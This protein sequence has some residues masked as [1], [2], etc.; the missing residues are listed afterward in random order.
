MK[1]LLSIL[2]ATVITCTSLGGAI[3]SSAQE[4]PLDAPTIDSEISVAGTNSF[5]SLLSSELDSE[6]TEQE[7]NNGCNVFSAEVTDNEVTVDFETISDCT[8]LA[9]IYDESEEALIATGTAPVTKEETEKT[10]AIDID[11]MPQY[12]YL[13]VYLVDETTMRPMCSVYESP[14]YTQEM[15]E[16]FAMTVDDF[17]SDR[18]LNFD[19]D[20]TNNFAVYGDSAIIV[21]SDETQNTIVSADIDNE[22]YVIGNADSTVT[23]LLAGDIFAVEQPSGDNLIIKVGEISVDGTTV[24]ITGEEAEME[25]VFDYVKIDTT[26]GT[27]NAEFDNSNLTDGVTYEGRT[28]QTMPLPS[29]MKTESGSESAEA[30]L[31]FSFK[32]AEGK[33]DDETAKASLSGSVGL[34]TEATL[35]YYISLKRQYVEV[36]VNNTFNFSVAFSFSMQKEFKLGT[37]D[38]Y[39]CPGVYVSVVPKVVFE[40]ELTASVSFTVTKTDGFSVEHTKKGFKKENLG[41]KP[42]MSISLKVE[43]TLSVGVAVEANICII[44]KKIFKAGFEAFAKLE[45]SISE[46]TPVSYLGTFPDSKHTCN[47]CLAGEISVKTGLSFS[48]TFLN[49]K[50]LSLKWSL[51]SKEAKLGDLYFSV[52]HMKGD[53]T[54]CP[55]YSYR[56]DFEIYNSKGEL[57]EDAELTI[58]DFY[59]NGNINNINGTKNIYLI[60]GREYCVTATAGGETAK[61]IFDVKKSPQLI[62]IYLEPS[63]EAPVTTATAVTT[64]TTTTT[65]T[66]T[67]T[68]PEV[69]IDGITYYCYEDHAE[70]VDCSQDVENA[71]IL[72]EVNGLPV[73]VINQYCYLWF[74]HG[75]QNLKT[76]YIPDSVSKIGSIAFTGCS[77]LTEIIVDDNNLN[78]CS[79]DGVLFNKDK[80]IL[81]AYPA[82][83][84][85]NE[86]TVPDSV[87]I[88]E[89]NAFCYCDYLSNVIIPDSV[90][91][92]GNFIFRGCANLNNIVIP[93]SVTKT[94]SG[95]FDSCDSLTNVKLS[96]NVTDYYNFYD[97]EY[98]YAYDGIFPGYFCN[99]TMLNNITIPKS[100][101]NIEYMFLGCTSLTSIEIP[102]SVTE[103][104]SAFFGCTSLTSIT[105]PD[106]V[107]SIGDS[108]F[109]GCTSLT[110]ITIHDGV[111][112][113][114]S[115]AFEDCTSLTSI[116]IPE[117]VKSTGTS[118]F[119]GCTSLTSITIPDSVTEISVGMFS[120]CTSLTSITIPD[121]VTSIGDS[122]FSGCSDLTSITIPKSVTSIGDEAFYDCNALTSVSLPDS[123]TSIGNEAFYSCNAL[124]SVSLPDSV[125]KI[126]N[127]TFEYCT[128]LTSITIPNSVTKIGNDTFNFCT[129]LTSITI[130]NSVTEIGGNAFS[131]CTSLTSIT[132]PDSV[133]EIGWSAFSDCTSLTDLYYAGTEEQWNEIAILSG[134]SCLTDATIHYNS[135][136][137]TLSLPSPTINSAEEAAPLTEA[138]TGLLPN[139]TYNFY[140][141]K[142]R[143]AKEPFAG[144]NLLYI[145]QAVSDENGG[146][147]VSYIPKETF[148]TA[149]IFVAGLSRTDI[150]SAEVSVPETVYTGEEIIVKP[151]VKLSGEALTV[152]IDYTIES[153]Y[154]VTKPGEYTITISGTG[155]YTGSRDVTFN[156][157]CKHNYDGKNCTICGA[158]NPNYVEA[159][160]ILLGDVDNDGAVN[161][162]DASRVLAEYA[163]IAT[164]DTPTFTE[165]QKKAADVNC[166]NAIDATDASSILGYYAFIATGGSGAIEEYLKG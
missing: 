87:E 66:T 145:T 20:E 128:S 97:D 139:E 83:K 56:T 69:T 42:V 61:L 160:D 22:K 50:K 119:Y 4:P 49:S 104:G 68:D 134:N 154:L 13:K 106:S 65:T 95:V 62:T 36:K 144:E 43:G 17:E 3:P 37:L 38:I 112:S 113:I 71:V 10:V 11:E 152:G 8:L 151:T 80:T 1:R 27:E 84:S 124:T 141:M 9:A 52:D 165:L 79:V 138:F 153:G 12:F 76:A 60:G 109:S 149:D 129:S 15:Q 142:S 137:A 120:G 127:Y 108:A 85:A 114:D 19:E 45:L 92:I 41:K 105:I 64:V 91:V 94:G 48:V 59:A 164:G 133:T 14:N 21:Q 121:N 163:I 32:F 25:E 90:R 51:F 77:N 2:L 96:E 86:Y 30:S 23:S 117:S 103:I 81:L 98:A 147:T 24:S 131:N 58:R 29:P 125:T 161:A 107:T 132:I 47:V 140:V 156:V 6:I 93:D 115:C 130:P 33:T 44:H 73:T 157:V 54:T 74:F 31:K 26:S 7:E 89:S 162:S 159:P 100:A 118:V 99:C 111:T 35:K 126:G 72:S 18:I 146:L 123:V 136:A 39:F 101:E 28:S 166:D 46:T 67:T 150:S 155:D 70:V 40:F 5:G 122:A 16:F 34:S 148:E 110:S 55:Y 143:S 53:L 78:Y 102:D 116:T 88:I 57:V 63:D 75:N 135:T 82:G 158:E